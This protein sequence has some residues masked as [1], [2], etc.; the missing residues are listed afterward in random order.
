MI[1]I[2]SP[3]SDSA[4]KKIGDFRK[5]FTYEMVGVENVTLKDPLWYAGKYGNFT[6]AVTNDDGSVTNYAEPPDVKSWDNIK[7]DGSVGS[8]GVPDGYFLARRP[9]ILAAQ[10]RRALNAAVKSSNAAPAT[11]SAQLAEDGFKYLVKFDTNSLLGTVEA[12]KLDAQGEFG[13]SP[14]WEAGSSLHSTHASNGGAVRNI[15]TN[16]SKQGFAFR[17]GSLSSDYKLEMTSNGVNPLTDE[18]AQIAINYIRGDQSKEGVAG[19]RGRP[20]KTSATRMNI[21]FAPVPLCA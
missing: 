6:S 2:D 8:D 20:C 3:S 16:N 18:N 4:C 10:L 1:W 17:W 14:V 11:S 12:F 21:G 19:L 15:I 7:E 13:F 9:D 5:V